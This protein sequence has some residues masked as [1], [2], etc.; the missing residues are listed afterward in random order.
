[1][2][3][4]LRST[5]KDTSKGQ[6]HNLLRPVP[7][8]LLLDDSAGRIARYLCWTNHFYP[9]DIIPA[10]LSMLIYHL[11]NEQQARWWPQFRDIV[12]PINMIIIIVLTVKLYSPSE[13]LLSLVRWNHAITQCG[14]VCRKCRETRNTYEMRV[15]KYK[16]RE[17][18]TSKR[19]WE[20]NNTHVKKMKREYTQ[21]VKIRPD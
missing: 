16:E 1:M 7:S 17:F 8:A 6:I 15:E 20:D 18:R 13:C 12:S 4:P 3:L 19:R 11:R 14:R 9:V 5:N 2:L 10:W 21:T